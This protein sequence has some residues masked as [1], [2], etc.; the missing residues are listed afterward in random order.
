MIK[1]IP[2]TITIVSCFST[3]NIECG[4]VD[5]NDCLAYEN[6]KPKYIPINNQ[7]FKCPLV[8]IEIWKTGS[9]ENRC[10]IQRCSCLN[11]SFIKGQSRTPSNRPLIYSWFVFIFR[12]VF[13]RSIQLNQ[14]RK[15]VNSVSYI[16]CR[17]PILS[18]WE[19]SHLSWED[20][21][22]NAYFLVFNAFLNFI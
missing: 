9:L 22:N 19:G 18:A 13:P 16:F 1:R 3:A 6:R 21:T 15:E 11:E 2:N 4:N 8:E 14:T 5:V 12:P 17:S 10:F 20:F 7:N